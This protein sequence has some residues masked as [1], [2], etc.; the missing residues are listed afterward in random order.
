MPFRFKITGPFFVRET[1]DDEIQHDVVYKNV[2]QMIMVLLSG[3][4][5]NYYLFI[6][7]DSIYCLSLSSGW[8]GDV[9]EEI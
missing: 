5:F 2:V 7:S 6:Q 9:N 4:I 1:G 3:Y 8:P